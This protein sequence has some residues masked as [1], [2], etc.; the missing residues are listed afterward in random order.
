L[1]AFILIQVWRP[2]TATVLPHI[3]IHRS[4]FMGFWVSAMVGAHLTLLGKSSKKKTPP[5]P[6]NTLDEI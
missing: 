4:I 2:K 5:P 3:F 1:I 6:K